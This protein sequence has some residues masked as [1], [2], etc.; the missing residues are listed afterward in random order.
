[1]AVSYAGFSPNTTRWYDLLHLSA[2]RPDAYSLCKEAEFSRC[3]KLAILDFTIV[4]DYILVVTT[5]GLMRSQNMEE[6]LLQTENAKVNQAAKRSNNV[7]IHVVLIT[8]K[9]EKACGS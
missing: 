7:P 2:R 6:V 1:M 4:L 3:S 9:Q 8:P 5:K